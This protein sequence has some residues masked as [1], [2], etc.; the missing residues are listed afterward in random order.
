MMMMIH[1]PPEMEWDH[2][3]CCCCNNSTGHQSR[4]TVAATGPLNDALVNHWKHHLLLLLLLQPHHCGFAAAAGGVDYGGD[5]CCW[6]PLRRDDS[7]GSC[8]AAAVAAYSHSRAYDNCGYYSP[9]VRCCAAT[10]LDPRPSPIPFPGGRSSCYCCCC[11][12]DGGGL[13][14][15][16]ST[17]RGR[18][19]KRPQV[20]RSTHPDYRW[21]PKLP[22]C[23]LI[24][25]YSDRP[26]LR[27]GRCSRSAAGWLCN[28]QSEETLVEERRCFITSIIDNTNY[29]CNRSSNLWNLW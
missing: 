14:W 10:A 22:H 17:K 3:C 13:N 9:L 6:P 7:G 2:R 20:D 5:C 23:R 1:L 8:R 27:S 12:A 16:C 15:R 28:G 4:S 24:Y 21:P 29:V 19:M 25:C 26:R 11:V 18:R